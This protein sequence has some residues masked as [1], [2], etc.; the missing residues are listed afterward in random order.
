MRAKLVGLVEKQGVFEGKPYHSIKLHCIAP[1]DD[2]DFHGWR[3]L[4]PKNTSI[5]YDRLPFVVGRLM[6][7]SELI[8]YV[9]SEIDIQFNDNKQIV[10][11]KFDFDEGWKTP[12]EAEKAETK[13]K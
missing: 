7:L 5:K 11:L 10:G 6:E 12:A 1:S 2:K 13:G 4:D 3:V 8:T 9:G